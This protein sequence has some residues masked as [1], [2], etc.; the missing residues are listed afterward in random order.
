MHGPLLLAK[1]RLG[2]ATR[3]EMFTEASINGKGYAA[4]VTPL[5]GDGMTWGCWRLEL[6]KPGCETI[7]V[8]VCDY[9]S[10]T[11]MPAS[12]DAELFSIWF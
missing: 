12:M 11:D 7:R 5:K 8:N 2:G 10:G 1:S 4:R 6:A 9:Q 3:A